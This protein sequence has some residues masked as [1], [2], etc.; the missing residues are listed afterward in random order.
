MLNQYLKITWKMLKRKK[1]YAAI[2]LFVIGS[3]LMILMIFV[4]IVVQFHGKVY[5]EQNNSKLLVTTSISVT[6]KDNKGGWQGFLSYAF[7]NKYMQGMQTPKHIGIS[8]ALTVT[9]DIYPNSKRRTI[10][11][12][13]TDEGFWSVMNFEFNNGRPYNS[14]EVINQQKVVVISQKLSDDIFNTDPIGKVINISGETFKVCGVVKDVN[15]DR[16][17]SYADIWMPVTLME[18]NQN[19]MVKS[20]SDCF[21]S[22]IGFILADKKADINNIMDEFKLLL[23]H[24]E[25]E[26]NVEYFNLELYPYHYSILKDVTGLQIQ[27]L[28]IIMP[29]LYL[30]LFLIYILMPLF[31][32]YSL[33]KI[34]FYERGSEIG[35][36][37]TFGA[38]IVTLKRQFLAENII[39]TSFGGI[40][41]FVLALICTYII[42]HLQ[43]F[44]SYYIHFGSKAILISVLMWII[45]GFMSGWVSSVRL[46]KLSTVNA[47]NLI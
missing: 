38:D 5:P 33:Q 19:T 24:I 9:E 32:L 21:G 39:I 37:K 20:N 34:R 12:R 41:G 30:L 10:R 1:L 26:E 3:T 16:I 23:S 14:D 4:A 6:R 47:L 29:A 28:R 2:S 40:I 45:F 46:S 17:F 22:S 25:K 11:I 15:R 42:N 8:S 18:K 13:G 35:I 43:I 36:R 7:I 44:N 27:Q 31:N